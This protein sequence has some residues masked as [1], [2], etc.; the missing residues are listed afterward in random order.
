MIQIKGKALVNVLEESSSLR[1]DLKDEI[2]NAIK[3]VF[4]NIELSDELCARVSDKTYH[5]IK[6]YKEG[7]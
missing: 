6:D 7:R 2:M 3:D 5:F 4:D 1:Q